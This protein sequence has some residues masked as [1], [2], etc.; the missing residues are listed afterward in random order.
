MKKALLSSFITAIWL[1]AIE[2]Q[3]VTFNGL[4]HLSDE[5]ATEISG[6]KIGG[7]FNDEIASKAIIN[8][9]KQGYFENIYI[10]ENNGNIVVNLVEKPVIAKIDINGVVTNDQKSIEQIIDIKKGQMYDEFALNNTKIRIRQFYEARGYFDTVVTT[11][12]APINENKNS[13]HITLTVNRGENITIENVNLIGADALDY[14]DIE[15]VVA[16]KSREFMGW[17][18]GLN[19]GKA[20]IYELPGDSGKIQDEYLRRGYLDASVSA[21]NLNAHFDN[22]KADLS[23]YINE[24]EIYKTGNIS[25]NAPDFLEIDTDEIIDDFKLQKGDTLNS[26]WMNL[27]AQK[28]ENLVANKGFAYAKVYPRTNKNSDYTADIIYE[29]IPEEKVYIRNVIIS[30]N[31]RTS[32]RVIRRDLYLTE[33]NLYSKIDLVDSKNALKRSGYFEDVQIVEKRIS[34]DQIDLE[35]VVKETATGSIVGGI[36]YGSSDGLL[37]NAGVSDSN[38]FGSGYKGSIM[39]DKSDDTL[40]GNINLTNPRVNDSAYSLGGGLFANDYSWDEYDEQNYGANIIGGRQIG[41]YINAYLAY[42]IERSQIEGLDEF[43]RDAGYQNGINIKSAITPSISFNNTDDYY[44][45]RSGIIASTSL[46]YAGVGGDMEF[47]KNRTTF[48]IYQGLQ[49]YI[50]MDLI[51]R[52]KSG[53][54]YIF[55][56]DSSKLPINEKLFLG[57]ISSLRGYDSRSVTPKKKI[58]NPKANN[59]G[60]IYGC[61][62]IETGGKISFNNSFELSFPIINRLK[63]RGVIFYDYG[64]IG[65]S[66]I[67]EIKRSSAGVGIEWITPI[68]PLQL[69]YAQALDDKPGDDTSSFEFTIGRRF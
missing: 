59:G 42:Q 1:H 22:Y 58:C 27:D 47:I 67:N 57:G 3:S 8:L 49:D 19:D 24:G 48:N 12:I 31:D 54:G 15:P 43:Y 7:Q 25:I 62:I 13:L 69:F 32:D 14:S 45:P 36:G 64:M 66:D 56:D 61:E 2:I 35:V 55:N 40:S 50:D 11:D 5:S 26:S 17:M 28:L 9:Y 6:L 34:K 63:M 23:Y 38:I 21:P 52:Y 44:V 37:L 39:I 41:R 29:V 60:T 4:L 30:G 51:F 68:G 33:G 10:E 53:F 65:H 20:K 46:E 18:W 16:N